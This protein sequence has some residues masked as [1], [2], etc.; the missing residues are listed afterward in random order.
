[1]EDYKLIDVAYGALLHDIG[2]FYQRTYEKSDLSRRELE[3]TRYHKNGNYYSHLHSGYTSR[4]LNKYLEMNNEFEKLTSEHHHIDES[5]HFL[6]II[7]K[8]DQIASAIDR[9]DEL[10]DNEAENK[11]GSFITARLYS[12][13]SEVHFGKEKND[14]SIF[15]LSTRDQ[16]NIPDANFVRKSLKESVDEYKILFDEFADEIEKNIYLKKRVNFIAY[17][18]MYN[19]LNKYLVTVPASTYGGVKSAVSLFDHLKISSAIASCL[20]DKTCYDQEMFY[21]LEIDVS[22][23]QSFIYQVVEGSGTKPGL[24]KALRGRSILVGLITNAISYA[25]LNEFGLTVSNILFNTGGGSMILLPYNQS[26][27]KRVMDLS[28][29]IRKSLFDFFQTDIT[30][31]NAM[32]PVN[33]KELETFQT[34][35]AIELKS[36]LGRNKMRKYQDIIDDADFFFDKIDFNSKCNTCGRVSKSEQCFICKMV[37]KISQIY[38]KNE[39]FGIVYDFNKTIDIK[40]IETLDLG[41]VRL[42]FINDKSYLIDD[43]ISWY[44]DSINNFGFGNEIMTAN[45]VPLDKDSNTILSFEKI[46]KLTPEEYG[47][48]KLAILKMDV[49]NLGG[50]FAFGLKA[51]DEPRVQRS[52]SKYVTM[53]RLMEFFFGH[54]IKNICREVSLKINENIDDKVKNGTM[55]YINYAGGDDLVI[56]GSAY[57]IVE[58]ALEIHKRFAKFTNNKNITISGGINFQNDKKPIRFGVQMAEEALSMSKDGDKNAITLLNTTVPFVEFEELL[59]EVKEICK[60]I[61]EGKLSRTMLFNLM[62]NIR[63]KSYMEFVCL[64]PRIQY[65]LYR[66][67]K[68]QKLLD[69]MRYR[70]T[71]V[72]TDIDVKYYVLI[73]KLVMLFTREN[74]EE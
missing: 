2:K 65:I 7:K 49:D 45:D 12:V 27:E 55:F 11:K 4:F 36:L 59:V 17:N 39:S 48:K 26:I 10:K 14:N 71:K 25:F 37:E 43:E 38:T 15:S 22:G 6:N 28:K 30:F 16:M 69:S 24:S 63:D 3:T 52:I 57:S 56:I 23:I 66:N 61:L 34:D 33:K 29:K 5:E 50:I 19:L 64:I 35:K 47:D 62:S 1:M 44:V 72:K 68:D 74:K 60:F 51:S 73:L 21:M 31:V 58:L 18:Y 46:L 8:A 20:Y 32:L 42:L 70:L 13:L 9:Q 53:S 41:F 40:N 54:E 67:V